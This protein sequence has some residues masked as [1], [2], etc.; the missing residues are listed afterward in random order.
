MKYYLSIGCIF[1]NEAHILYE[2]VEHHLYHGIEHLYMINDFSDDEFLEILTPYIERGVVTLFNND[3]ISREVGRQDIIYNKY[4]NTEEILS[5]SFWF[6][7][8]DLD[9]FLYSPREI[10]IKKIIKKYEDY[11]LLSIEWIPFG[12]NKHIHQPFS[13][14]SAFTRHC[15]LS[16]DMTYLLNGK[17]DII[18]GCKCIMKSSEIES[19]KTHYSIMKIK[20]KA[21]SLGYYKNLH[22][23]YI[24][25]YQLQSKEF[26]LTIKQKRGDVDNYYDSIGSQRNLERFLAQ[27]LIS[28]EVVYE[29]LKN[30][31]KEITEKVKNYKLERLRNDDKRITIVV[32]NFVDKE[33][34]LQKVLEE[35]KI[36]SVKLVIN[37]GKT[38]ID[39]ENEIFLEQNEDYKDYITT[40]FVI[41]I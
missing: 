11:N 31:N 7:V 22:E 38:K 27:D 14:V 12:S 36:N 18:F 4:F 15:N 3:V 8:I 26:F 29:E 34:V 20:D 33:K 25:H 28:N 19:F 41:I 17:K 5:E 24:N 1:K 10:D 35:I 30:Q 6:G 32:K 2:F 16:S 21:I 9:E 13:V 39:F 40:K 23:L 37:Y